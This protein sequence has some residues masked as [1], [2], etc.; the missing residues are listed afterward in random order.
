MIKV[1]GRFT[2][3]FNYRIPDTA[4]STTGIGYTHKMFLG[5][6]IDRSTAEDCSKAP[7]YWDTERNK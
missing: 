2:F 7:C 5:F 3:V 1:V 6:S 4:I